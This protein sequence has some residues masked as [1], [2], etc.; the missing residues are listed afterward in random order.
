MLHPR[1]SRSPPSR[2]RDVQDEDSVVRR[3][4]FSAPWAVLRCYAED[5][6]LKL[7]LQ[8]GEGQLTIPSRSCPTRPPTGQPACWSGWGVPNILLEDVPDVPP[9]SYSC[10]FEVRNLS[11]FLGSEN[12]ATFFPITYRHQIEASGGCLWAQPQDGRALVS[13]PCHHMTSDQC[14]PCHPQLFEILAK[15][16]YGHERKRLFG[17][18]QLLGE[19]VFSAAFPLHDVSPGAGGAGRGGQ[20]AAGGEFLDDEDPRSRPGMRGSS[21]PVVWPGPAAACRLPEQLLSRGDGEVT[22]PL[23]RP[24]RGGDV[25]TTPAATVPDSVSLTVT[26]DKMPTAWV[27]RLFT[28]HEAPRAARRGSGAPEPQTSAGLG[29]GAQTSLDPPRPTTSH[30]QGPLTTPSEGPRALGLTQ[31][32]VR[33]QPWARWRQ[34]HKYQPLDHVRRYFGEKVAF[35]FARLSESRAHRPRGLL[36]PQLGLQGNSLLMGAPKR[37]AGPGA[38]PLAMLTPPRPALPG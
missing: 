17:T 26:L 32:Q 36:G 13:L 11:R 5:L 4:L 33:L 15:T 38:Q 1:L 8:D 30:P 25:L 14:H 3:L 12:Q 29:E 16:P 20:A 6:G 34:W 9:K 31:R 2:Q 37:G 10:Q 18:D 27:R 35:Y 22:E 7:P 23:T 21:T 19:G 28:P 24:G